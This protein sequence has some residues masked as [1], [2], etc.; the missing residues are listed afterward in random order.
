MQKNFAEFDV[1]IVDCPDLTR[2][3]FTLAAPGIGGRLSIL[4][5]GGP[6]YLLPQVQR[7]K[8]YDIQSIIKQLKYGERAFI[9]GAGA[10]PWP[11]LGCNCEVILKLE[12]TF[13]RV[14]K[15]LVILILCT[16]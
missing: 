10:G 3:P 4:E 1:E 8:V 16:R 9:A 11:Y 6:A 13:I 12:Y 5:V 15:S 7:D 14:Y 2:E